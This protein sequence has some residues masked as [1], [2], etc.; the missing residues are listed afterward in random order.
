M[1][2]RRTSAE[3][4]RAVDPDEALL[5]AMYPSLRRFAAVV[6]P[7]EVPPDDLVHDAIVAVLGRGALSSLDDP[8]RYLRRAI[9]NL[10]ANHRRRFGRARRAMRL[11][12]IA[13]AGAA[14]HYPSDLDH[15][16]TL[17]PEARAVLYLQHVEGQPLPE[18]AATLGISHAA[19]RQLSSRARRAL[20]DQLTDEETP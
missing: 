17:R 15:L 13:G 7:A 1:S 20:R 12:P 8:L 4:V 9:V 19:A 18:I 14:D 11:L 5:L 3:R 2:V 6:G 10:A 16:R